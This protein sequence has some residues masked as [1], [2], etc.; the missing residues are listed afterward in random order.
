MKGISISTEIFSA[1][2]DRAKN[3]LPELPD[4]ACG[5]IAGNEAGELRTVE[6]VYMLTNQ[7]HSSEHFSLSP[8]EQLEAVQDIR[9][10]GLKLL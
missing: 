10:N 7:D 1:I 8:Q 4:E 9:K 6:K 5:L 3:E 2:T